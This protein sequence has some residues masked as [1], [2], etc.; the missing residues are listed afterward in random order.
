MKE[1]LIGFGVAATTGMAWLAYQH[2]KSFQR[3][4]FAIL[5]ICFLLGAYLTGMRHGFSLANKDLSKVKDTK[6]LLELQIAIIDHDQTVLSVSIA[7]FAVII[8]VSFFG[9]F[10]IWLNKDEK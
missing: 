2:P 6:V 10:P 7:I 1:A 5:C 3:L 9:T 8:L 4:A